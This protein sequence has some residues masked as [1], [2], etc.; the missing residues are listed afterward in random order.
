[1][2]SPSYLMYL[3]VFKNPSSE[4]VEI[5]RDTFSNFDWS[6]GFAVE[7]VV[8]NDLFQN[9]FL[10]QFVSS[11]VFIGRD[12]DS[13]ELTLFPTNIE[14]VLTGK[15]QFYGELR[16][17]SSGI[18]NLDSYF[19]YLGEA[20]DNRDSKNEVIYKVEYGKYSSLNKIDIS[21]EKLISN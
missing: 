20:S 9:N 10:I 7:E 3:L 12:S 17:S 19:C 8:V 14:A 4:Q 13:D 18:E 6:M 21:L 5:I 1:M 2:S 11:K 15:G 16:N